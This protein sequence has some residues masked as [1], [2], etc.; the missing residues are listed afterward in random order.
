MLIQYKSKFLETYISSQYYSNC[1][2]ILWYKASTSK[3][4]DEGEAHMEQIF[5]ACKQRLILPSDEM[6]GIPAFYSN[7]LFW[8]YRPFLNWIFPN[9][10]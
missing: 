8:F 10:L 1:I 9:Q 3:V 5:I 6:A 7:F 4:L 2:Y